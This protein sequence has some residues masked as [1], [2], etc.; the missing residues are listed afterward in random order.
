MPWVMGVGRS[1]TPL[2]PYISTNKEYVAESVLLASVLPTRL[3]ESMENFEMVRISED[4]S[5]D[6]NRVVRLEGRVA[7]SAVEQ[8]QSYC[9]GILA[10]GLTLTIDMA[11]V[12]FLDR[13]GVEL[14]KQLMNLHVRL[15]NCSPFVTEL[16]KP[17]AFEIR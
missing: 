4:G 8:I 17:A 14:F 6:G 13:N 1:D 2:I 7:G 9:Q 15:L 16:L 3:N 10:R 11:D 5:S 12:S